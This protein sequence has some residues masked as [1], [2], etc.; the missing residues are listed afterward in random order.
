MKKI[1]SGIVNHPKI[2]MIGFALAKGIAISLITVFVFMPV[3]IL[4]TYKWIDKT[5][6]RKLVPS[7]RKFGQVVCRCMIPMM[8]IFLVIMIPSYLASNSNSFYYG[9]SHIFNEKTKL[10]SDVQ[11][12]E[13]VFGKN[14]TYVLMLPKDSTA[15]QKELS[16]SLHE[17]PEVKSILSYVDTV[18][19][20]IPESYLDATT[21]SKLNSDHYTRMVITV[22]ADYEGDQTFGLVVKMSELTTGINTLTARYQTLDQGI[23]DYTDGVKQLASGYTVLKMGISELAQGSQQLLNGTGNLSSGTSEL[24]SGVVSLCD[25]TDALADGNGALY[26]NTKDMDDQIQEQIDSILDSL[27]GNEGEP[28]SFVSDKNT[29]VKSVQFVIKTD[30]IKKPDTD[31]AQDTETETLTF[32]QKLINLFKRK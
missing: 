16:D 26:D 13:A 17:L 8:C 31:D 7:F 4:A 27:G 32:W 1:Y 23:N 10:G 5:R 22:E 12:V 19:S 9:A 21:L 3:F 18:G 24:Y 28:E 2:V 29:D 6:H 25:G 11:K 14:D 15:T 30:A 20:E